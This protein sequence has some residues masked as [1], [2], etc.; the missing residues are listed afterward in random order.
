LFVACDRP[1]GAGSEMWLVLPLGQEAT[2]GVRGTVAHIVS[3]E[4]GRLDNHPPGMG[5]EFE[6]LDPSA[7]TLLEEL[8]EGLP[9]GSAGPFDAGA[10]PEDNSRAALEAELGRLHELRSWE[11][12]EISRDATAQQADAAF[13]RLAKRYHPDVL[14]AKLPAELHDLA[15][16]CFYLVRRAYQQ[17]RNPQLPVAEPV[18]VTTTRRKT[19]TRGVALRLSSTAPGRRARSF[20]VPESLTPKTGTTPPSVPILE[21]VWQASGSSAPAT[22]TNAQR[23]TE[24]ALESY[25]RQD[26]RDARTKLAA[27]LRASPRNRVLLGA[28]YASVGFDLAARGRSNEAAA[29]FRLAVGADGDNERAVRALRAM[30]AKRMATRRRTFVKLTQ[31]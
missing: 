10:P 14:A 1:L 23:L 22:G 18:P 31:P 9:S 27:A 28:Y 11:I 26:Y 16:E 24:I 29:S 4:R 8:L 3:V 5:I 6:P 20:T 2:L 12:L 7:R 21:D 25:Q 15:T 19:T 13:H 30:G 17:F